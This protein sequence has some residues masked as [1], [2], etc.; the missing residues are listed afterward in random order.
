MRSIKTLGFMQYF[1][2]QSNND[3]DNR[4]GLQQNTIPEILWYKKRFS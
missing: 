2:V 1:E 4:T 3:N